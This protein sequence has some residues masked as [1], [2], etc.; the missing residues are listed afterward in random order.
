MI[1]QCRRQSMERY[2]KPDHISF[3]G[4]AYNDAIGHGPA[5]PTPVWSTFLVLAVGVSAARAYRAVLDRFLKVT[6]SAD[7]F[8]ADQHYFALLRITFFDQWAE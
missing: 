1:R 8:S 3:R 2:R 5:S 7:R 6:G 4:R